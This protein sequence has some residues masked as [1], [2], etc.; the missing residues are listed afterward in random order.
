MKFSRVLFLVY[1][2]LLCFLT[3]CNNSNRPKLVSE[4]LRNQALQELQLTLSTQS[5][6]V[7]VHAAEYLLWLDYPEG[8]RKIFLEEQGRYGTDSPYRIG[9]WRVLAQTAEEPKK[10]KIWF[11]RI[12]NAY[13]NTN[14]ADRIHAAETLAKLKIAPSKVAPEANRKILK[15]ENSILAI[16]TIWGNGTSTDD[17][18]NTERKALLEIISSDPDENISGKKT[19][20]Y[21]LRHLRGLTSNE[22]QLLAETALSEP[23]ESEVRVYML[24]AAFV[25]A[26]A[27]STQSKT[28]LEI[29]KNLLKAKDSPNKADRAEMAIALAERGTS[30]DLPILLSLLNGESPIIDSKANED[31]ILAANSDVRAA[32]AYA[33]LRIDR[34]QEY[35]LAVGDWIVIVAYLM[36]MIGIGFYYSRQNKSEKDFLLG[37]G[38]MNPIA[39]G[40]SLFATLL[41][42]LT[43]LSIPGEIIKYGPFILTGMLAFPLV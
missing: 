24:S 23:N 28:Y 2:F 10:K 41:S 35:S 9:I 15:D 22:W 32:A 40:M 13:Q 33:I 42:S 12:I 4:E 19:A 7:K 14:G 27:D 31:N 21:A 39:V 5:E 18:L 36:G 20:A 26:P 38:K 29:R 8:V 11:N 1:L 16:C 3:G 43:Y 6:W 37:G 34:K 30:K 25:A 17:S